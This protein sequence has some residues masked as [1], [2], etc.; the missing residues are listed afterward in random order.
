MKRRLML[1]VAA[2]LVVVPSALADP[3]RVGYPSSIASTGD[4]ITRAFNTGFIPYVDWPPN[5]WS[6]GSSGTV[7][8]HY[9]RILA[10]NPFILG[11]S[12]NDAVSGA[13]MADLPGQA[14]AAVSQGAAY[15]TILMGANDACASSEAAMTPVAT[16]GA[17]FASALGI[18]SAGLPDARIFVVSIPDIHNLWAIYRDSANARFVW[19]VAG[20]CQS[21]LA[22]PGST[23]QAD[24]DRRARVRQRVIDYNAQL[25]QVCAAYIHCRFDG[26]LIFSTPFVRSDVTTRDYFHPSLAGQTKLAALSWS[27]TFDFT[28]AVAPVSSASVSAG[29]ATLS[30]TDNVGVAGIEYR[31]AA[32]GP[33]ARYTAPIPLPAGSTLTYRAVDVNGNVEATKTVT[34]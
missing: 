32:S 9:R 2:A 3:A 13:D 4:S 23:A 18:L 20:I 22:R 1:A 31:F 10:A 30:A 15:V 24:V 17:Q 16:F 7:N 26:N 19:T 6:T 28:D 5:S 25:Q 21:M 27:A 12:F 34:G 33:F 29:A 14:Q 8:S 11:R